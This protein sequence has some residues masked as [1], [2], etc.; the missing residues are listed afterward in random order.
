MWSDN[1]T[2]VDLLGFFLHVDILENILTDP[3]MLP[4]SM[5]I[6]GDWGSGKSSLMQMLAVRLSESM[7]KEKYYC[8]KINSWSF[9]GYD[10]AKAALIEIILSGIEAN[11]YFSTDVKNK[12][13]NL[14]KRVNWMRGLGLLMKN[15]AVPAASAYLTGGVSL[16]PFI[17]SK[18]QG[19]SNLDELKGLF[20]SENIKELIKREE[21]E[22]VATKIW[23]FRE[24][25]K[26][27]IEATKLDGM[28]FILDDLDRCSPERI[29][30]NLEA[31]KL[32]LNVE[33][34]AF[35]IGIDRRTLEYAIR[36]R[37]VNSIQNEKHLKQ[38][39]TDYQEK[40][41]QIPYE[42]PKLSDTETLTYMN[43]LFCK[44]YLTQ[45]NYQKVIES[46][47]NFK[48]INKF[49]AFNQTEIEKVIGKIEGDL[50]ENL[51]I[52]KIISEIIS[53]QLKGNPRQIKRYLNK[54]MLRKRM[55]EVIK[56]ENFD[57]QVLAKLMVLEY[58]HVEQFKQLYEWLISGNKEQLTK[59]ENTNKLEEIEEDSWKKQELFEWLQLEPKLKDKKITDYFW[60]SRDKIEGSISV[61]EHISAKAKEVFLELASLNI[62][63]ESKLQ[64]DIE[65]II[66][67]EGFASIEEQL[68]FLMKSNM[69][70][71]QRDISTFK[72]FYILAEKLDLFKQKFI[73]FLYESDTKNLPASF[74]PK[75]IEL[76]KTNSEVESFI[77]GIS[78]F[79]NEFCKAIIKLKKRR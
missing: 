10:D 67:R 49:A 45:E 77:S 26:S 37:Y 19:I 12:A 53:K 5:G 46:F 1:E 56:I 44:A 32:F 23:E 43:L 66:K 78:E 4:L 30:E 50:N 71:N 62:E 59:I 75:I 64:Q 35:I 31:I 13:K 55:A 52:A 11:K 51:R 7:Y 8:I 24:E 18:I 2:T 41:I 70:N 25:F 22:K 21:S 16:I 47:K 61:D 28:I 72:I 27:L 74:A 3:N 38:L 60:I 42:L 57:V 6:Y 69:F 63:S 68:A 65:A 17:A 76:S 48:M 14:F 54:F 39:E 20:N 73:E 9:E 79:D 15:I 40:L 29:I 34:T 58:K 36:N 33:K